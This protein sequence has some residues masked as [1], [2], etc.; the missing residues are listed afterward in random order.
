VEGTNSVIVEKPE[1]RIVSDELWSSAHRVMAKRRATYERQSNGRL[2]NKPETGIES[3]RWAA[4]RPRHVGGRVEEPD[5]GARGRR[6]LRD[7]RIDRVPV[8]QDDRGR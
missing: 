4:S 6:V 1:L 3:T 8:R 2:L 7:L 5:G